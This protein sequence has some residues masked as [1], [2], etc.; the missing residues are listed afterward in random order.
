MEHT[1]I[2]CKIDELGRIL[3]P[4]RLREMAGWE[5]CDILLIFYD[6]KTRSIIL[7]LHDKH[8]EAPCFLCGK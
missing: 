6:D 3:L 1:G 7:K 8:V 4:I 2:Y 5:V